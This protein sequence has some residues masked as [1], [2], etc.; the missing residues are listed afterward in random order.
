MM[1]FGNFQKG[2]DLRTIADMKRENRAS[3]IRFF[4][5]F[6]AVLFII[7]TL[8]TFFF[9]SVIVS[10]HSMDDT[11]YGGSYNLASGEYEGGDILVVDRNA[12]IS[13]GDVVVFEAGKFVSGTKKGEMW[14][15]RVAGL[16]GDRLWTEKGLLYRSYEIDGETF[17]ECV[18]EPYVKGET[19]K[20]GRDF[21][22]VVP[23]DGYYLLGDNREVSRDS[24]YIGAVGA[25]YVVGVVP[26]YVIE[27]KD[28]D[29]LKFF[30]RFM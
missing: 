28:S 25:Q 2:C 12:K 22:V 15:K 14:I 18:N 11:L 3:L 21:S 29:L 26:E 7:V 16:P 10:G 8:R 20:S 30:I 9:M 5:I 24:R 27:N 4:A 17:T 1:L 23:E 13:R 6:F 19:Y